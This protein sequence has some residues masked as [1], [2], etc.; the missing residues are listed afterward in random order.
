VILNL[1]HSHGLPAAVGGEGYS[2]STIYAE[3]W[4]RHPVEVWVTYNWASYQSG[5]W[6]AWD[7]TRVRYTYG[8]HAVTLTGVSATQVR[9][10]DVGHGTQ[11]WINKS[12][13]VAS[14]EVLGNMAVIFK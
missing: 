10:N 11:Y 6:T 5:V 12:T 9:V 1:A 3:L 4:S 2:A 7:G 8:E 14:W 13:F